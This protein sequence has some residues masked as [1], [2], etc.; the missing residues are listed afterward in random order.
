MPLTI[1]IPKSA[2]IADGS[3]RRRVWRCACGA[4]YPLGPEARRKRIRHAVNCTT[5]EQIIADEMAEEHP[6]FGSVLADD[7]LEGHQYERQKAM[8]DGRTDSR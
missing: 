3:P 7:V 5:A 6:T 8:R 4:E 1:W 2:R